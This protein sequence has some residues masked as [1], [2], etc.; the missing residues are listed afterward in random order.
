MTART[1]PYA[2]DVGMRDR[3]KE[4]WCNG[5]TGQ[6]TEGVVVRSTDTVIDVGCGYGGLIGF[7]AGQGARTIFI[8][9]DTER[10]L[11]TEN[12]IKASPAH[13]YR[14]IHSDCD[15][16]P[17]DQEMGD[18][19]I[20]TEVLEHVRD[21][22][23][24][25]SELVRITKP[26]G[27]LVIT[28][29]DGR[30]EIFAAATAPDSYFVEPNHIRVFATGELEAL[31][32]EAGLAIES[33][34]HTGCFWAFYLPLSWLTARDDDDVPVDNPHPITDHWT[35]LWQGVQKH[36]KGE[37]IREAFNQVLPRTHCIVA[38]KPVST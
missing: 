10:L 37:A 29:P 15:P 36:P 32:V 34:H 1:R 16:I 27:K 26:G 2:P 19:V 31:I 21:P 6:L 20:C 7:C 22:H 9:V 38:S 3:V 30:A 23:R 8:D 13:A 4:G 28:V 11:A 18:I 5:K 12:S 17:L 35:R 33:E 25:M 24:L 14:A